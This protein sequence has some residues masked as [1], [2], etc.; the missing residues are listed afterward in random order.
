MKKHVYRQIN[1]CRSL[2]IKDFSQNFREISGSILAE[3]FFHVGTDATL[4][5]LSLKRAK[6]TSQDGCI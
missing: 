5:S 3:L 4:L 1:S 6:S 2:D